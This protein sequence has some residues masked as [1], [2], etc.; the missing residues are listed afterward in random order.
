MRKTAGWNSVQL[1]AESDGSTWTLI[2]QYRKTLQA[3][4]GQLSAA[5]S[6]GND[7]QAGQWRIQIASIAEKINAM[8]ELAAAAK[9][10]A[11]KLPLGATLAV[12]DHG[13]EDLK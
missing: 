2:G 5:M 1:R 9:E 3:M 13:R 4:K 12:Q 6:V 7:W 8:E 10:T 11:E